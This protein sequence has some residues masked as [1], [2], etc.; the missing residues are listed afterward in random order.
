M[1]TILYFAYGSNMLAERLQERTPSAR[2]IGKAQLPGYKLDFSKQSIDGSGKCTIYP[3]EEV[4]AIIHGVVFQLDEKELGRLDAAEGAPKHYKRQKLKVLHKGEAVGALVYI[5]TSRKE[6]LK[7]YNWYK[8]LV[9]AGALQQG[10]PKSYIEKLNQMEAKTDSE[11]ERKTQ[12][13]AVS[14]LTLA[15]Y[16]ELL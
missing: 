7:P 2:A 8:A 16:G 12:K 3:S 5:A 1:S 14:V 10:L 4:G 9:I 6:G 15:G 13:C 11:N